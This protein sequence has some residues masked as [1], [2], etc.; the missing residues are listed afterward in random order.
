MNR[1]A[2]NIIIVDNSFK[3]IV[4][5]ENFI[6]IPNFDGDPEDKVLLPLVKYLSKFDKVADVRSK[7]KEDF[8]DPNFK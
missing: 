8:Y 4:Q 3:G 6:P 5:H 1:S 2:K 7:I